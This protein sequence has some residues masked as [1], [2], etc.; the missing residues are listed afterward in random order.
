MASKSTGSAAAVVV[1]VP[2]GFGGGGGGQ[3]IGKNIFQTG[4][5]QHLHMEFRKPSGAT[6]VAKNGGRNARQ[7]RQKRFVI[8]PQ[9]KSTT[10]TKMAKMPGLL[11]LQPT[12]HNQ[13]WSNKT[14]CQSTF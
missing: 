10:F 13:T 5:I 7:G 14:P 9:M 11:H 4:Q 12:I 2:D 3:K 6:V 1:T 8:C